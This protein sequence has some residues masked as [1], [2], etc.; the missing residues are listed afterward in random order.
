MDTL[1]CHAALWLPQA[2]IYARGILAVGNAGIQF[3]SDTG[4]ELPL[5]PWGD[6]VE[7]AAHDLS[8]HSTRIERIGSDGKPFS[9]FLRFDGP[10]QQQSLSWL[11]GRFRKGR[12]I[13][14]EP[15]MAAALEI[16]EN[17]YS[18]APEAT[19][20]AVPPPPPPKVPP[21]L[22]FSPPPLPPGDAAGARF[23]KGALAGAKAAAPVAGFLLA[24]SIFKA[25][26]IFR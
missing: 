6:I 4:S 12:G 9:V 5:L 13:P 14:S 11:H 1:E 19:H 15:E 23:A 17:Q 20:R 24:R 2:K 3:R 10:V 21:P 16:L 22:P 7:I 26:R 8:D 18:T 25:S